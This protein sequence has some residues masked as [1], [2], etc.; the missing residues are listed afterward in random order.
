[1]CGTKAI[2]ET[3]FAEHPHKANSIE[4]PN[5]GAYARIVSYYEK[6]LENLTRSSVELKSTSLAHPDL[7]YQRPFEV[8]IGGLQ[9][10]PVV[11]QIVYKE[12]S[13]PGKNP[14]PPLN[15]EQKLVVKE[16]FYNNPTA[17]K[18]VKEE[19]RKIVVSRR[20]EYL[21]RNSGQIKTFV[22]TD[23][24]QNGSK[25]VSRVPSEIGS[26]YKSSRFDEENNR[27]SQGVQKGSKNNSKSGG[28]NNKGVGSASNTQKK[29]NKGYAIQVHSNED[30]NSIR[31]SSRRSSN[32]SQMVMHFELP[33]V[34]SHDFLKSPK[35]GPLKM[36]SSPGSRS[37]SPANSSTSNNSSKNYL[38][39]PG[40]NNPRA[41]SPSPMLRSK[42][43]SKSPSPAPAYLAVMKGSKNS[44]SPS[45]SN[46]LSNPAFDS[47]SSNSSRSSSRN[48]EELKVPSRGSS[49]SKSPAISPRG[50]NQFLFPE[51]KSG[52]TG[53]GS[54][55]G[56]RNVSPR[57]L[58]ITKKQ[59][60]GLRSG[61]QQKERKK[62]PPPLPK[63]FEPRS[64]REFFYIQLIA[65]TKIQR[66]FR[67]ARENRKK[68]N[69]AAQWEPKDFASDCMFTSEE[70]FKAMKLLGNFADFMER[71]GRKII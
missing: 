28:K 49:R 11:K 67:K 58:G 68:N 59:K 5:S 35:A 1:M 39:L 46:F 36:H 65:A 15:Y 57:N 37:I 31:G 48:K 38:N 41:K 3:C 8:S 50:S 62:T 33:Q 60:Q 43:S 14:L 66:A 63:L 23:T 52:G 2:E 55:K 24:G 70:L 7:Q 27:S 16:C 30:S 54:K 47:K 51:S 9:D 32:S 13:P 61:K 40:T 34:K 22:R 20:N 12:Y 26:Y 71:N 19:E 69:S 25:M 18:F 29:N 17:E 64:L 45:P 10:S 42:D 53:T 6:P 44:R 56:S 4:D 21:H